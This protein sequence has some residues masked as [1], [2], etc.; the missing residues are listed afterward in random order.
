MN[1]L[2]FPMEWNPG[3]WE[4]QAWDGQRMA[5]WHIGLFTK[6]EAVRSAANFIERGGYSVTMIVEHDR[7]AAHA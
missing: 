2:V 6:W 4:S 3:R 1:I 7:P 5:Y